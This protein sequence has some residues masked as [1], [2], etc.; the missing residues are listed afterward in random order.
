MVTDGHS[1]PKVMLSG[2]VVQWHLTWSLQEAICLFS[3]QAQASLQKGQLRFCFST[4]G[5]CG[6]MI[7][8]ILFYEIFLNVLKLLKH[9]RLGFCSSALPA[10]P[11]TSRSGSSPPP[12]TGD[13]WP[14]LRPP[15]CPPS[16]SRARNCVGEGPEWG[17]E[18]VPP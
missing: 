18:G 7:L 12:R 1:Y 16:S 10:A 13:T 11:L 4:T 17:S 8:F 5:F 6:L 3:L 2:A 9:I 14:S 15:G